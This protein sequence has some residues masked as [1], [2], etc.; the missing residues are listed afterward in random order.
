MTSVSE[1]QAETRASVRS[2]QV[3]LGSRAYEVLIG[4][5]LL[6]KAG[7]LIAA[8]LGAPRCGIVTDENVARFHLPALEAVLKRA[9][10]HAGSVVLKPGEST[11]SFRELAPLSERLL[12]LGLERGDLVVAFGGGVMGDLAGFAAAI[13]LRGV[14][15]V[16]IPT[17]LLAQVDSS[18][19]GKTGIDTPQG[20]NLIGAFHQP[21]L[22]IAD[23]DTL[24]TLPEREMR[25]GYAEVAK[26]GLLGDAA[27]FAWLEQSWRS[28]F[29]FEEAALTRAIETSVKA[30]AG[31]VGRDETEQG[32]R[33]LLNLGH[34]FGHAFEAWCGYS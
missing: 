18:V 3:P 26:Y 31:I 12:E 15:F 24:R 30:K 20:K 14:R 5:G 4:P 17:T 25:A 21:S 23:T 8:R 1:S 28:V 11:K 16:Q 22:V 29:A 19:G 9:N 32:E 33:A 6:A 7:E 34:T 2:V 10:L 27:F 13:L